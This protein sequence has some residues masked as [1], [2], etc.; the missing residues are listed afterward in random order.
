VSDERRETQEPPSE[1]E[2]P[3][4]VRDDELPDDLQPGDDNPLAQ[5]AGDDV[6]DDLLQQEAAHVGSGGDSEDAASGADDA[7]GTSSGTASSE[8]QSSDDDTS[9]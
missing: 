3:L 9:G 2:G 1:E 8:S 4:T 7:S 6:P 5:P